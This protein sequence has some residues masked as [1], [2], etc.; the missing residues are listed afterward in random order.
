MKERQRDVSAYPAV[1]RL[2]ACDARCAPQ[3]SPR[4]HELSAELIRRVAKDLGGY[5]QPTR[6]SSR[7]QRDSRLGML[8][9][10]ALACA[11]PGVQT[12]RVISAS[13]VP[14]DT[15]RSRCT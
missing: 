8:R 14:L 10:T 6:P 1:A 11:F 15:G 9:R 12:H 4:A 13:V 3:V 7:G 2:M 5:P